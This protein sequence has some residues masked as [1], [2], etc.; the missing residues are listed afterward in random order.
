[1]EAAGTSF[2]T[3]RVATLAANL[4]S[5]IDGDFDPL[6]IKA[7]IIHSATFPGD[8]L[9]PNDSKVDKMGFG[10]PGGVA[11]ML[12]DNPYSSTLVLRDTLGKGEA[13]DILDFPMPGC[14]VSDG[15]FTGQ[16]TLTLVSSPILDHRQGSE[17][18][19]SDIEVK[20]GSYDELEDRD[21]TKPMILNPIGRKGAKNLLRPSLYSKRKQAGSS[22]DFAQRERMLIQ[23]G[24]K[25]YPVKKYAI[26]LA[27]LTDANLKAV[28]QGKHWFL[29]LKGTY[30]DAVERKS[31]ETGEIL[32][33]DFCLMITVRDPKRE[34]PVYNEIATLLNQYGFWHEAVKL[35]SNARVRMLV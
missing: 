25:Y 33:Q 27:E 2:S 13:I 10:I 24:G 18:C 6:L 5:T 3:P 14:L 22:E 16:I 28:E 23:Y 31:L 29:R 20:F 32:E 19:Q 9:V 26:D 11:D 30:R 4:A 15:R 7:M 1:M 8:A 12:S 34:A 21:I 35:S 17:Y